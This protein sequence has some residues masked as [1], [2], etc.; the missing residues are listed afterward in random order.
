LR[1]ILPL[2]HSWNIPCI[3]LP[4]TIDNDVAGTDYTLGHDSACNFALQAVEGVL[5]TAHALPGRI[6]MIET[7]GGHTGYLALAIA[8]SVGAQAVLVPE[9]DV[10]LAWLGERLKKT[11]ARDGYAL[12]VLAEGV[13]IIPQLAEAIPQLTGIRLRYTRLGHAQR[14]GD[15]SYYDRFVAHEV[16]RLAYAGFKEKI[17][18]GTVIMQSGQ[19]SLFEGTLSGDVKAPPNYD[20]YTFVNEL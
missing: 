6:F 15:V 17:Q 20:Q 3:G 9:Y 12:V 1:H 14:G 16:V 8:Y 5:A 13:A 18:I 4:T 7:L 11:V 19:L 2:L 10:S